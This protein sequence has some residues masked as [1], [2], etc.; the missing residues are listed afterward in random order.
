MDAAFLKI[1][2]DI[3][4]E[5]EELKKQYKYKRKEIK[6]A[7]IKKIFDSFKDF[8]KTEGHFKFK[9]NEH[10][11]TAEYKGRSVKLEMDVY[12]N[13]DSEDF[14]LNATI[15]T[16]E[17]ENFEFTAEGSYEGQVILPPAHVNHDEQ[18]AYEA[19]YY[20]DFFEDDPAHTFLYKVK[21]HDATYLSMTELLHAI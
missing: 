12:N 5:H 6:R 9:E 10:S 7:E 20:R 11:V 1:K 21:G 3:L 17:G 14:L 16:F 19:K 13:V 2:I 18:L 8:F 15:E 4:T